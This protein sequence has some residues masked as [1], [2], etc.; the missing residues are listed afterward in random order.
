MLREDGKQPQFRKTR[1]P[2]GAKEVGR[3]TGYWGVARSLGCCSAGL[4]K[5]PDSALRLTTFPT[6]TPPDEGWLR[7]KRINVL[8][9]STSGE[10]VV[11]HQ[12]KVG[13]TREPDAWSVC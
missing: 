9:S 5:P 12:A 6:K 10:E 7:S 8:R 2:S 4:E 11:R 13:K 3:Q 1:L